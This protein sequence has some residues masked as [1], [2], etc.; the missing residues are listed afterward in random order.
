M[1]KPSYAAHKAAVYA[2]FI[3]G[4][5][6]I[7]IPYKNG[8]DKNFLGFL[9]AGLIGL[10]IVF[11]LC[12]LVKKFEKSDKK[13]FKK[14]FIAFVYLLI[15]F[16]SV[17]LAVNCFNS[18]LRFASNYILPNVSAYLIGL[19]F[20][21]TIIIVS[22][23]KKEALYKLGIISAILSALMLFLLFLFS[24]PQFDNDKI[25]L[26]SF[27][28]P[29]DALAQAFVYLRY[30][31]SPIILL[32]FFETLVSRSSDKGSVLK[33][34]MTGVI[35]LGV[36]LLNSLLIFG[37]E[38]SAKLDFPYSEAISTVTAGNIFMRL[39]GFSYYVFFMSCLIKIGLSMK[40][41]FELFKRTVNLFHS[42]KLP[43]Q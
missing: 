28:K 22:V 5:A 35:F 38:L 3:L 25:M 37:N 31:L 29:K 26:L 2:L 17:R 9:L 13:G 20:A 16:F 24:I 19:I 27:P 1:N 23:S 43:T 12:F 8:N 41:L 6:G 4:E 7:I 11:L 33:G 42:K 32:P 15:A 40:L 14:F 10:P 34:Y 39:D 30:T 18:F 36:C 21:A